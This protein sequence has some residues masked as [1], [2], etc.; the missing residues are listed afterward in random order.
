MGRGEWDSLAQLVVMPALAA[1]ATE[2]TA[3]PG[4]VAAVSDHPIENGCVLWLGRQE[5][6]GLLAPHGSFAVFDEPVLPMIRVEEADAAA[7]GG[8]PAP[9]VYLRHSELS[10]ASLKAL[11]LAFAD[12]LPVFERSAIPGTP[13]QPASPPQEDLTAARE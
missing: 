1:A 8:R 6:S 10:V 5:A 9:R 13:S 12:R 4:L 11:A 3:R 7:D 2:L